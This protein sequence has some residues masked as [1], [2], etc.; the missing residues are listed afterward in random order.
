[1]ALTAFL[2]VVTIPKGFFPV[3]DTGLIQG[4]TEAAPSSSYAAMARRQQALAD[5]ILK[6]PD[7]VSLSL[8]HRRGRQQHHAE[9]PAAS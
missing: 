1:M 5:A 9:Q 3:Q 8:L 6:D 2:Y 7:V 4:I